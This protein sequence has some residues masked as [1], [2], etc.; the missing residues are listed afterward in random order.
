MNNNEVITIRVPSLLKFKLQELADSDNRKLGDFIRL[1]LEDLINESPIVTDAFAEKQRLFKQRAD[2]FNNV[3]SFVLDKF[4]NDADSYH[5]EVY[6]A[7][8]II[9]KK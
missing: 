6:T 4:D 9:I 2:N 3:E 8:G 7:K 5:K 1:K